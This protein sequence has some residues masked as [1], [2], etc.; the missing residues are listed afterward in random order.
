MSTTEKW[1]TPSVEKCHVEVF[2]IIN[3]CKWR[4]HGLGA[5]KER[6]SAKKT[7]LQYGATFIGGNPAFDVILISI[8]SARKSQM[9]RSTVM[10]TL[11]GL[12]H[13]T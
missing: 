9:V 4:K 6:T 3:M 10:G 12:H 11:L 7:N 5:T 13:I 1:Q 2:T 8:K